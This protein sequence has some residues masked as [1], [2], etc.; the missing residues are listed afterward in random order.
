MSHLVSIRTTIRDPAALA[1]AC[2]RLGLEPPV[3]ATARLFATDAAGLIVKLPGWTY[4]AVID[5]G[6]GQI[7]MDTYNGAWGDPAQLDKLLQIY[8][9]E[10]A[11]IEARKSGYHSVTEQILADGS[12]KL[13][14]QVGGTN[15]NH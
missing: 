4:P 15:E 2:A 1:V 7:S 14:I 9:V 3:Q 8:A 6:T 5:A 12:I 11:R 10:K 13:V